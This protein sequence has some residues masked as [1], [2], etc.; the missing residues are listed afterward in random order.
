MSQFATTIKRTEKGSIRHRK[1][2]SGRLPWP[3]IGDPIGKTLDR[4][5]SS[6]FEQPYLCIKTPSLTK[7]EARLVG[8]ARGWFIGRSTRWPKR[9]WPICAHDRYG[10]GVVSLLQF[11]LW[12]FIPGILG[13]VL[14]GMGLMA[15][16][17]E[18]VG[19]GG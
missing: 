10:L 13:G 15:V 5:P 8:V 12:E 2:S 16:T 3:P 4:D 9:H 6:E 19:T 17:P 11:L 1:Y 14:S 18:G 7:Q